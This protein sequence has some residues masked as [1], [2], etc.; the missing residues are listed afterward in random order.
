MAA[1][2]LAVL[3]RPVVD[4]VTGGEVELAPLRFGGVDLHLVLGRHRVELTARDRRVRRVAQPT[5]GDGGAEVAAALRRRGAERALG[6]LCGRRRDQYGG[7]TEDADDQ[8][9]QQAADLPADNGSGRGIGAHDCASKVEIK[10]GMRC[11]LPLG[12]RTGLAGTRAARNRRAPRSCDRDDLN[13]HGRHPVRRRVTYGG[14]R[15]CFT[16]MWVLHRGS[17]GG[18]PRGVA[19]LSTARRS[20]MR[21][22]EPHGTRRGGAGASVRG[23]AVQLCVDLPCSA[24]CSGLTWFEN[25]N[26][27]PSL[28]QG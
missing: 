4:A 11:P 10:G 2:L 12:R 27:G 26:Y 20:R 3:H 17:A 15:R 13:R 7:R 8:R 5:R 22:C 14:R 19:Y 9:P 24:D 23:S 18:P 16:G 21:W 6:G 1:H 28:R 25:S